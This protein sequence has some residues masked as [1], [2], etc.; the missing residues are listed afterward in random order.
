MRMHV[1]HR[2]L[3]WM[4]LTAAVLG[5]SGRASG[6]ALENADFRWDSSGVAMQPG[7]G[8]TFLL[9]PLLNT[10]AEPLTLEGV[11]PIWRD[12]APRHA[13]LRFDVAVR[14]GDQWVMLATYASYPPYGE[15]GDGTCV[16][17]HLEP[18]AGFEVPAGID[19][20][21]APHLTVRVDFPRA[22]AVEFDQLR[23]TYTMGGR[24]YE[25]TL[26]YGVSVQA[27][28]S[29]PPLDPGPEE[30]ACQDGT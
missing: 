28:E 4:L 3:A 8:L 14:T 10:A 19:D 22:E 13:Q 9:V 12:S 25:Q 23:V 15:R 18:V 27:K 26:D 17:Q 24:R 16:E 30:Q 20:P 1:G 5:C 7:D 21:A 29:G 11:E 2:V 6:S